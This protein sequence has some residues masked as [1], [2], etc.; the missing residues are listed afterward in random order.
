MSFL[1]FESLL[2]LGSVIVGDLA[3]YK[4]L[5]KLPFSTIKFCNMIRSGSWNALVNRLLCTVSAHLPGA[6]A[7]ETRSAVVIAGLIFSIH[8]AKRVRDMRKYPFWARTSLYIETLSIT[9]PRKI[10]RDSPTQRGTPKK[11]GRKAVGR[12]FGQ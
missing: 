6:Q 3:Q 12:C 7:V 10:L 2:I 5:R 4:C 11:I 9:A 1:I 8:E